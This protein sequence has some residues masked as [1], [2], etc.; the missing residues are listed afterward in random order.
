M[1]NVASI[2]EIV[3][4]RM[5]S[6]QKQINQMR[7]ESTKTA[8]QPPAPTQRSLE[9][10]GQD[11]QEKIAE[12]TTR[13]ADIQKQLDEMKD[14]H[15]ASLKKERSVT[16]AVLTQKLDRL[17]SDKVS[18]V[19]RKAE[20]SATDIAKQGERI[21]AITAA[22]DKQAKFLTEMNS[23]ISQLINQAVE[24]AVSEA[25]TKASRDASTES[26]A[27]G[28][29]SAVQRKLDSLDDL[30]DSPDLDTESASLESDADQ[31]EMTPASGN[32]GSKSKAAS[33]SRK[34]VKSSA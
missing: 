30:E 28:A 6:M 1:A 25:M 34:K 17:V 32:A 14:G 10:E 19:T 33:K 16:E 12:L 23:R 13:S 11:G 26:V 15:A 5:D 3:G 20:G 2:L 8:S 7:A 22:V 18:S 29:A 31:I 9:C 24:T 21:N 27:T 4:S